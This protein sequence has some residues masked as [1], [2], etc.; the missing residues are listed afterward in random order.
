MIR[1]E[2]IPIVAARL[3]AML[4]STN[5]IEPSRPVRPHRAQERQFPKASAA[6]RAR[7]PRAIAQG[8]A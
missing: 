3:A 5:A 8:C 2:G 6:A 4:K 1:I 7:R